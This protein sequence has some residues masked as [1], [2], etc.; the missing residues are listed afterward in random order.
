MKKDVLLTIRGVQSYRG[1]EPSAIELVTEGTMEWVE[2]DGW[3]LTYEESVLTGLEGA[4]TSFWVEPGKIIL[5]RSGA[6]QAEM[7]FEEGVRHDSLYQVEEGALLVRVCARHIRSSLT[8]EGGAVTLR[9]AIEI[10]G[11]MAGSVEYHLNVRPR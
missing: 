5:R 2:P 8:W 6:V 1:Q 11:S 9:Y 4:H 7:V 10:E 3:L